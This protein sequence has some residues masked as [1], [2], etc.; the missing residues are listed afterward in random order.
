MLE[1]GWTFSTRQFRVAQWFSSLVRVVLKSGSRRACWRFRKIVHS[2]NGGPSTWLCLWPQLFTCERKII[3]QRHFC[4]ALRSCSV[5]RKNTP[6]LEFWVDIK[7]TQ[8]SHNSMAF[9]ISREFNLQ[10]RDILAVA[11]LRNIHESSPFYL[12]DSSRSVQ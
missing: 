8:I 10:W 2:M 5:L 4:I 7:M 11:F 6:I 9:Q 3:E 1:N 12:L